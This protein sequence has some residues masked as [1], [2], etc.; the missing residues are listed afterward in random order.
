MH[1]KNPVD[2][3]KAAVRDVADFPKPG[4]GFKDITPALADGQLFHDCIAWLAGRHKAGSVDAVAGID[5][6]GFILAGAVAHRLGVGFVPIRK[7][8]K[9]PWKTECVSYELE[10]G[11]AEIEIH[12][13]ALQK[14]R[15]VLVVDDVLA[16]GGTAL[17]AC[18][19][20]ERIGG[21]VVGVDFLMGLSFLHGL[22]KLVSYNTYVLAEY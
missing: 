9:L 17:A 10:Y 14:G 15:N 12:R 18:K 1:L 5:A 2:R 11:T 16:T 20:V 6:R 8:G 22:Q 3:L 21:N 4:V 13:D 19:L 7:K